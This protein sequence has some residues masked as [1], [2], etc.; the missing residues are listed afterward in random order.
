VKGQS[1]YVA[2]SSDFEGHADGGVVFWR[3]AP[4]Q[5]QHEPDSLGWHVGWLNGDFL[6]LT[7]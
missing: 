3:G 2:N 1:P 7:F 4:K 6:Q 5:L